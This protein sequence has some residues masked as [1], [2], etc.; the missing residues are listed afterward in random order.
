MRK[1]SSAD[2]LERALMFLDEYHE[3]PAAANYAR[4]AVEAALRHICEKRHV[5][6]PFRSDPQ[7]HSAEEFI[8]ALRGEKLRKGSSWHLIPL[9]DQAELRALRSTVLN[10]LSHFNPTTVTGSEI[11]RAIAVAEKLNKLAQHI[12]ANGD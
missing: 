8:D 9:R 12:K 7:K 5:A 3:P 4:S 6:V 2:L 1:E 11:R 10:P